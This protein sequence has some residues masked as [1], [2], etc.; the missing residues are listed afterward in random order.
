MLSAILPFFLVDELN[1]CIGLVQNQFLN[2][3]DGYIEIR[4][5][6]YYLGQEDGY[7]LMFATGNP[8]RNGDHTGVFDEDVALLSG[9][10]VASLNN[11]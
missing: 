4:G 6:K 5:E 1:R 7:S 3:A 10:D 2:I 9:R 11:S 8:P